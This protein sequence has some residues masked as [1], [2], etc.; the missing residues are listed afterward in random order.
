MRGYC[1]PRLIPA[2]GVRRGAGW[3]SDVKCATTVVTELF[4]YLLRIEPLLVQFDYLANS[5]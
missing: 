4:E 5:V 2:L 1:G 3:A